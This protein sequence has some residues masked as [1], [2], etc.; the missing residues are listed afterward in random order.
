MNRTFV[1]YIM[2]V[3]SDAEDWIRDNIF[4]IDDVD[5][6]LASMELSITGSGNSNGNGSYFDHSYKSQQAIGTALFDDRFT[7][8]CE[9]MCINNPL[10]GG[11]DRLDVLLR[12]A[13]FSEVHSE[14]YSMV[15]D[16]L[17]ADEAVS[18]DE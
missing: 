4:Y 3:L 11:A 10:S 16:A 6:A 13:A 18:D 2:D 5:S 15:E 12:L 14:L 9:S 8:W 7:A 1:H 17:R